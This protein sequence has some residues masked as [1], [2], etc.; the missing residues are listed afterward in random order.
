M[1]DP[2]ATIVAMLDAVS[3]ASTP[4]DA[5]AGVVRAGTNNGGTIPDELIHAN[6]AQ[7][8]AVV[9]SQL[10]G[11]VQR[12]P[13]PADLTFFYF[14]LFAAADLDS[15]EERAGFYV[16]GGTSA[17]PQPIIDSWRDLPY[18]PED[19]FLVSPLLEQIK[20]EALRGEEFYDFFDYAMMFGAAAMLAKFALRELGIT[21][22]LVVGFDSGD[23]LIVG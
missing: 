22:T 12:N 11:I 1:I 15:G 7:E 13:M 2:G 9:A 6:A 20:V 17:A 3:T 10:R 19:R 4:G 18:F 23:H 16:S 8:V 21:K 14:G 5:W